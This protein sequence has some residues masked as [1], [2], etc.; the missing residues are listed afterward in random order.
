LQL[1]FGSAVILGS[2]SRGT[3][4][5]ILLSHIRDSLDLEGKVPVLISRRNM[6]DELYLQALDPLFITC[7]E[8]QGYD[9]RPHVTIS[10]LA[11]IV[12]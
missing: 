11:F 9:A 4:G 8:S 5:H 6:M 2:E 1:V 7:Y 10:F 3:F 12:H